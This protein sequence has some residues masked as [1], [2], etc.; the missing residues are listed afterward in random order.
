[1]SRN[2]PASAPYLPAGVAGPDSEI[3]FQCVIK[4]KFFFYMR[5]AHVDF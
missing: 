4:K 5:G 2:H 3:W 1:M